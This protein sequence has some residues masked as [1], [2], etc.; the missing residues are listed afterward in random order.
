MKNKNLSEKSNPEAKYGYG[1]LIPDEIG[2]LKSDEIDK[3]D[4]PSTNVFKVS[5][6]IVKDT[7]RKADQENNGKKVKPREKKME[8]AESIISRLRNHA[9]SIMEVSENPSNTPS[10]SA[11]DNPQVG[12]PEVQPEPK[13]GKNDATTQLKTKLKNI[14]LAAADI[15]DGISEDSE[16]EPWMEQSI[17]RTEGEIKKIV[18]HFETK[19]EKNG[20]K[21]T[22]NE[23]V[24][25]DEARLA[26]PLKGHSYHTKSE[27]ELRYIIQDASSAAKAMQGHNS[28]AEAKYLDQVN[29][30]ATVLHHRSL[31]G[32]QVA[33]EAVNIGEAKKMKG[34]DPCWDDYEMV[35]TKKKGDKEVPN[36]VAKEETDLDEKLAADATASDY[37]HDFVNSDD[38]RFS[39]KSKEK[40]KQ[41]ALAAF[42]AKEEVDLDEAKAR[43]PVTFKNG[44]KAATAHHGGDWLPHTVTYSGDKEPT[45]HKEYEDAEAEAQKWVN[46]SK[47]EEKDCDY[48]DE[49]EDEKELTPKQK[50]I[51]KLA[52]NPNKIDAADFIKLRNKRKMNEAK[53]Y[54]DSKGSPSFVYP[55]GKKKV[56]VDD[57]SM[58]TNDGQHDTESVEKT[59]EPVSKKK[60]LSSSPASEA[61]ENYLQYIGLHESRRS[62][63]FLTTD[64]E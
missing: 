59:V 47:S 36:C 30:A 19:S 32:K 58:P 51:A 40:R 33:K 63:S 56:L 17:T 15:H 22:T 42:Y 3:I 48:E 23:E 27:N 37:I 57:T 52:D 29:D 53:L 43:K 44:D 1:D 60:K 18:T 54:P 9:F 62:G 61:M 5:K 35:G 31:G 11:S 12:A 21:N 10:P 6:S 39:G 16:I 49:D 34:K 7:T 55:V 41:M 2:Y 14:A 46:E 25:L 64:K 24:D 13:P 28:T 4:D 38:P 50:K 8:T 45:R 26:V 20:D